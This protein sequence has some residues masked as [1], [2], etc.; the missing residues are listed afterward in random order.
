MSGNYPPSISRLVFSTKHQVS[1][2]SSQAETAHMSGSRDPAYISAT[3][4]VLLFPVVAMVVEAVVRTC[5]A[6]T[7]HPLVGWFSAPN[8]KQQILLC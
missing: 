1:L 2:R 8:L 6:I 3:I 5:R 7:L 4:V